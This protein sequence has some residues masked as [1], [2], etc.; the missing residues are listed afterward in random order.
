V[1]FWRRFWVTTRDS[2][3]AVAAV[4]EQGAA[5]YGWLL[6]GNTSGAYDIHVISASV[7]WRF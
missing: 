1:S 4:V 7:I 3:N 6:G 2:H 5:S